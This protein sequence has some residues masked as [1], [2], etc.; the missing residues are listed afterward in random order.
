MRVQLSTLG[1]F[2]LLFIVSLAGIFF[3]SHGCSSEYSHCRM[4]CE[5]TEYAIRYCEDW[6]ICCRSKEYIKSKRTW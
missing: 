6:T 1:V 3:E 5:T 2:T 4:K